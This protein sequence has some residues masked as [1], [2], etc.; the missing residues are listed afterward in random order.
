M[1][2]KYPHSTQQPGDSAARNTIW[3]DLSEPTEEEIA[4][5]NANWGLSVPSRAQ[6]EEIETSSR[7]RCDGGVLY[8]SMPLNVWPAADGATTGP[9]GFAFSSR[10]LVSVR[11]SDLKSFARIG[12]RVESDPGISSSAAVFTA[13]VE[14]MADAAADT[15]EKIAADIMTLSR[16]TFRR[17]APPQRRATGLTRLLRERLVTLGS[18]GETLSQIRES[19]LGLG[20][21]LDFTGD[22]AREWLGKDI[23]LRLKT[24][25]QDLASL[26]DFEE[27][28]FTKIHFLLD[29]LLG[30][31]NT[32]QNDIFKVLTIASVVGI[33]PTLIAS[34]YGMNFHNMPELSWQWGYAYGLTLIA[35]SIVVPI[36]WFKRRGWW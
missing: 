15:L 20:R 14:E 12:M 24:V 1:L 13:L 21:I 4:Q 6:L 26:S 5:V 35:L 19:L 22:A 33:P 17:S 31:V 28:L 25:R 30:F 29:A 11:F 23:H 10:L 2:T 18:M 32:E 27:H 8:L 34:M 3:I 16:D 7:L 36:L 9:V